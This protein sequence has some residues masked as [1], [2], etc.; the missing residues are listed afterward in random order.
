MPTESPLLYPCA[1]DYHDNSPS[2]PLVVEDTGEPAQNQ[3]YADALQPNLAMSFHQMP[4]F[5]LM[6]SSWA[7]ATST[8]PAENIVPAP[9]NGGD[10]TL[11]NFQH[12]LGSL[13]WSWLGDMDAQAPVQST[14]S[15][16]AGLHDLGLEQDLQ[17]GAEVSQTQQKSENSSASGDIPGLYDFPCFTASGDT[18]AFTQQQSHQ[19]VDMKHAQWKDKP[20]A[21]SPSVSPG[22][23]AA[24]EFVNGAPSESMVHFPLRASAVPLSRRNSVTRTPLSLQSM[25]TVKKRKQKT[26]SISLEQPPS[27]KP[28]Q[29]VQEDGKGGAVASAD[30]VSPPRGARR[31]GPL[32]TAGRANAGMRRKNKDTCVQ[33]RLNKRK[34]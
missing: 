13:E 9:E 23:R 34:V 22:Y 11:R 26:P 25:A 1:K 4:Q 10:Q 32:S 27:T 16:S 6:P 17:N 24:T 18:P 28:L 5:P 29:I 21:G 15:L 20:Q 8:A 19:G 7:N 14:A 30:F 3:G 33:C 12:T 31:K 2:N